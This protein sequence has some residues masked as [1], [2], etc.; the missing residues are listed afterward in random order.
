VA[1]EP[2]PEPGT[3]PAGA[4]VL[5]DQKINPGHEPAPAPDVHELVEDRTGRRGWMP[6]L[7]R[8]RRWSDWLLFWVVGAACGTRVLQWFTGD[9]LANDDIGLMYSVRTLPFPRLFGMLIL[10]QGAPPG[11]LTS[12]RVIVELLGTGDRAVRI[13]PMLFGCASVVAVA[14]LARM[15]VSRFAAVAATVLFGC[16]PLAIQYSWQVKPYS[17]DMAATAVLLAVAVWALRQ[18]RWS[19]RHGMAWWFTAAAAAAFS[20][21]SMFVAAASA[22]VLVLDRL[23]HGARERSRTDRFQVGPGPLRARCAESVRFCIPVVAWLAVVA[24][25]YVVQ[26]RYLK[27]SQNRH[28]LWIWAFGPEDGSVGDQVSW[29]W[30]ILNVFMTSMFETTATSVA[31]LLLV[32]GAVALW[33][34]ERA[35]AALL[36]A[37]IVVALLVAIAQLYPLAHRMALW[38]LPSAVVLL[39][40]CLFPSRAGA[41]VGAP[42]RPRLAPRLRELE[43]VAGGVVATLLTMVLLIPSSGPLSHA[44]VAP[45]RFRGGAA[46]DTAS[47]IA[48]LARGYRPGD[49]ILAAD[50]QY[51]RVYWYGHEHG[52]APPV[53]LE[54][55]PKLSCGPDEIAEAV[56]DA[57]RVWLVTGSLWTFT[58][59]ALPELA[60]ARLR[61]MGQVRELVREGNVRLY[62]ADLTRRPDVPGPGIDP[63]G[64]CVDARVLPRWLG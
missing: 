42:A 55:A 43:A 21:P 26:L 6:R 64:A 59:P 7:P 56:G 62:L 44:F 41:G 47:A 25:D 37:P 35:T 61:A 34:R 23:L 17:A 38:L 30:N 32:L 1:T 16:A 27:G 15:T 13:L 19:Y 45:G 2:L 3:G 8:P 14:W 18:P 54:P 39:A 57:P 29:S 52:L 12:E 28:P 50:S 53:A 60:V 24:V 22:A 10:N 31:V 40:G 49:V 46:D 48:E 63:A 36:A 51:H 20:F 5:L 58:R 9:L 11:W 33:W 4:A